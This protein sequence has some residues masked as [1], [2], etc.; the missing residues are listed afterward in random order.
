M[1]TR[2]DLKYLP[3]ELAAIRR[4]IEDRMTVDERSEFEL[5][6]K[7]DPFLAAA[8]EGFETIP[9]WEGLSE[10]KEKV[11]SPNASSWGVL[12]KFLLA[13]VAVSGIILLFY[14]LRPT[15]SGE[16]SGQEEPLVT[17]QPAN[18]SPEPNPGE[19]LW[20]QQ[21]DSG[22]TVNLSLPPERVAEIA[23]SEKFIQE[24]SPEQISTLDPLPASMISSGKAKSSPSPRTPGDRIYHV[25]NYKL[26][27]YRG[28]RAN[29]QT[30]SRA[31][32]G[33]TPANQSPDGKTTEQPEALRQMP[34]VDYLELA[35]IDYASEDFHSCEK[36]LLT[37]LKQFPDDVNGLFYSGMCAFHTESYSQAVELLKK[38][39][40]NE[41]SVFR[42]ESSFYL[43]RAL[44]GWGREDE[45]QELYDQIARANS[46]YSQP[47]RKFLK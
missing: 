35:I 25:R 15:S 27:D 38:V 9:D 18:P 37:I 22:V 14:L 43:A 29:L 47:A 20:S 36:K 7:N 11:A 45:A 1:K 5:R 3:E 32:L 8:V 28:K 30:E 46:F 19:V 40:E 2:S 6:I 41:I 13:G 10:I 39:N 44:D 42:E 34:Y 17:T 4:Y 31:I 21:N 33:G 16:A 12:T 26:A 24:F 23:G